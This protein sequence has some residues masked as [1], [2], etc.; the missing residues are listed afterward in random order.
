MSLEEWQQL[1]AAQGLVALA[2]TVPGDKGGS[3]GA[4]AGAAA[5]QQQQ[6]QQEERGDPLPPASLPDLQQR[7]ARLH[8]CLC[9]GAEG[10]GLS[11]AVARQCRPVSIPQAAGGAVMDSLNVAAAG[12]ILMAALSEGAAPLLAE[13]ASL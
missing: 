9:L 11:D 10:Q 3:S 8:V 13:L 2:A 12:A 7:L 1:V 6:Q 4:A 5:A